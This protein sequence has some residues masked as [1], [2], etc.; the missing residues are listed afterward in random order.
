M[1]CD[2]TRNPAK[3]MFVTSDRTVSA[4]GSESPI[5]SGPIAGTLMSAMPAVAISAWRA[6]TQ[7]GRNAQVRRRG[8][9]SLIT[10]GPE[11]TRGRR[12]ADRMMFATWLMTPLRS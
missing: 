10:D 12:P 2:R 4:Y 5:V 11:G 6:G 9:R 8:T 1:S 3:S 7:P